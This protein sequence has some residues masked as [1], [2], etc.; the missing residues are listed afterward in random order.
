MWGIFILETALTAITTRVTYSLLADGWG[1]PNALVRLSK[2]DAFIPVIGGLGEP[3]S[4]L[5]FRVDT[6]PPFSIRLVP[7][8]LCLEDL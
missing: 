3:T 2:V 6:E 7:D 5:T 8:V 1:V 4:V